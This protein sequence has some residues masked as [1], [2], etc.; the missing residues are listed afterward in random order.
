M[1]GRKILPPTHLSASHL[2]AL[3]PLPG[4][5]EQKG[6]MPPA[7]EFARGKLRPRP[8]HIARYSRFDN[9]HDFPSHSHAT[10]LGRKAHFHMA[11]G[12]NILMDESR[13]ILL[14]GASRGLGRAMTHEFAERGHTVVGCARSEQA[15][16][17]LNKLYPAPHKFARVDVSSDTDVQQ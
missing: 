2:F 1:Q 4:N 16:D 10:T 15:V 7:C 6:V 11:N 8:Y 17:Q 12:A 3:I 14:T 9:N 13:I 5:R